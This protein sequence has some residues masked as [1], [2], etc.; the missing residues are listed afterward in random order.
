MSRKMQ[1]GKIYRLRQ[2]GS[3]TFEHGHFFDFCFYGL[4]RSTIL[5][6]VNPMGHFIGR[7]PVH[8]QNGNPHKMLGRFV[9]DVLECL[10]GRSFELIA[11]D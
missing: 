4:D 5:G 7:V 10:D 3:S 11:I 1:M 9:D 2:R 6:H 8:T